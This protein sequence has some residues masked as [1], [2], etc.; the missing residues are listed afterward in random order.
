MAAFVGMAEVLK[1]GYKNMT[2]RD[3][4]G[5]SRAEDV[6]KDSWQDQNKHSFEH[7]RCINSFR[8]K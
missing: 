3:P 5:T 8:Q 1:T 4:K 2:T 6:T 7:A